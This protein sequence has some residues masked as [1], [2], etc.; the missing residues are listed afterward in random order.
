MGTKQLMQPD[1]VYLQL[2]TL[3]P[4]TLVTEDG[5]ARLV[6]RACRETIKRAVARGELPRPVKMFGQNTWTAGA[7]IRFVEDRLDAEQR[8]FAPRKR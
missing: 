4:G 1:G 8:K 6:G 3:P 7:I 2:A 5:L